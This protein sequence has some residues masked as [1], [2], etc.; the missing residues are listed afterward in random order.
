MYHITH[1]ADRRCDNIQTVI[2]FQQSYS[3]LKWGRRRTLCLLL[4]VFLAG[5][6]GA[7]SGLK[8]EQ[9]YRKPAL[10]EQSIAEQV[11][12]WLQFA[13]TREEPAAS[14]AR[15]Q[16][17]NLLIDNRQPQRAK[18]IV[19]QITS[20]G[21]LPAELATEY[22]LVNA[23]LFYS[24]RQYDKTLFLLSNIDNDEHFKREQEVRISL[25]RARA[26]AKRN[27]LIASA[28]QRIFIASLLRDP[29]QQERNHNAIWRTLI[30]VPVSELEAAAR[31]ANSRELRGWLALALLHRFFIDDVARQDE[32]LK[33]WL[34]EWPDHPA[35]NPLP[36]E[37]AAL[38]QNAANLPSSVTLLLP[39][40]GKL[41]AAGA[42]IRD[43]FFA[44]YYGSGQHAAIRVNVVD[45]DATED[46]DQQY[47]SLV[48]SGTELIIGPL[49]KDR[50][51][52]ISRLEELP[53]PTLALNYL[54]SETPLPFYQ[55]GLSAEDEA[56]QI[57]ERAMMDAHRRALIISPDTSWG[58]RAAEAFNQQW[59]EL[60]GVTLDQVRFQQAETV[61]A[62]IK[63][64]LHVDISENRSRR[65]EQI[66]QSQ[67][68]F[69]PRRR[70]DVDM[71]FLAARPQE[72]RSLKPILAFH[73]GGNIPVYA[74]SHIYSGYSQWR[75]DSDLNG[76][77]FSDMPWILEPDQP[78]KAVL[79]E[80][81]PGESQRYGRMHAFGVDAFRLISRLGQLEANAGAMLRGAT[82]SLYMSADKQIRRRLDFAEI[83]RGLPV[84]IPDTQQMLDDLAGRGP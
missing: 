18:R 74:T 35:A 23:R 64:A 50:V 1:I 47:A 46:F 66:V 68:E 53:A 71:I 69:S 33:I 70:K 16:A 6:L 32:Q 9:V 37:L 58:N 54:D 31:A 73:Y 5:F 78:L 12:H 11:E 22:I 77:V 29:D 79:Q 39:L 82:G 7:C 34:A 76:I 59:V 60:G 83:K 17:A 25:L 19:E 40:S 10:Q 65:I 80:Y 61:S 84:R 52:M 38:Q 3:L 30:Q 27:Q 45:S 67:I 63:K 49:Q 42:A 57:A 81:L 21:E 26:L 56:S 44:A 15:L 36:A 28:E 41:A 14:E 24:E 8:P 72:A 55:F 51:E 4:S 43:G 62:L 2:N 20:P 75:K 13:A 48:N